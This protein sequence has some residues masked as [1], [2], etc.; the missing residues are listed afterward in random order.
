M[1]TNVTQPKI[2]VHICTFNRANFIGR[3]IDSVRTQTYSNF[4]ILIIDDASTDNTEQ[5]VTAYIQKDAR[6]RYIKNDVNL[7]ITKNRNKALGLTTADFVAVLDSDDY[8]SNDSK[9]AEQVALLLQNPSVGI[10]GT[11]AIKVSTDDIT[12]GNITLP[13]THAV[14]HRRALISNPFIHSSVVYR[15]SI[16]KN[17]DEICAIWED[18]ATW[19]QAGSKCQ[20]ANIPKLYTA[21]REHSSNI[22][23]E[24]KIRNLIELQKILRR[25]KKSYPHYMIATLKNIA[26]LLK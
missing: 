10:V 21:Y 6:I 25:F 3:A 8:W 26:R 12:I 19:L 23:K 1:D 17:Y 13:T 18:Y 7:G 14:L 16:I 24:K 15:T 4:E 22:S 2:S 20:F 11:W 5:V 9:L